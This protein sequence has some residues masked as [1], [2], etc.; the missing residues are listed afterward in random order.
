MNFERL[1]FLRLLKNGICFVENYV[2][3]F[4]MLLFLKI[5][6]IIKLKKRLNAYF[7][8]VSAEECFSNSRA[9]F[10]KMRWAIKA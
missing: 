2:K 8:K 5:K 3:L 6:E 7:V 10:T 9:K 4:F 1:I